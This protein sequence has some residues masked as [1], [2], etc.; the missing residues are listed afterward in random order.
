M[1][2]APRPRKQPSEK[3]LRLIA[4]FEG[5]SSDLYEDAAGH[6]TIGFGHLVHTGP[7]DGTE[8]AEFSRGITRG[9]ALD[10]LSEDAESAAAT[11][12]DA[13]TVPLAQ[14][15]VDALTS[16]VFNVGS[17]AFRESTLLKLLNEGEYD[18]VPAQLD[19]WVKAGS[20]R[21]PGL[22]ARRKAEGELF[23]RG[24]YLEHGVEGIP[25]QTTQGPTTTLPSWS[26][27]DEHPFVEYLR[28]LTVKYDPSRHREWVRTWLVALSAFFT[29]G[30]LVAISLF[31]A[32]GGVDPDNAA[33][34]VAFLA[35]LVGA[36]TLAV[37]FYFRSPS[38]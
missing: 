18:D 35:P 25:V 12:N 29:F 4:G 37:G 6:C 16:F 3:C 21:L 33:K 2:R 36:A 24:T 23:A 28:P 27:D 13:V 9:R 34:A 22:V 20:R 1:A 7:C 32:F 31:T 5:F 8:S 14:H 30:V 10:I 19:R 17:G 15:Q 26:F 38:D 11:V